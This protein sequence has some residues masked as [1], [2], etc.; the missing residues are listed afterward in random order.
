[1]SHFK[2]YDWMMGDGLKLKGCELLLYGLIYSYTINGKTLYEKEEA[3]AC[4]FSYSREHICRSI[5]VLL[6]KGYI[7]RLG[8]HPGAETYDYIVSQSVLDQLD[9]IDNISH[10]GVNFHH[11]PNE[12]KVSSL[13]DKISHNNKMEINEIDKGDTAPSLK[14][15]NPDVQEKWEVLLKSVKW[16]RRTYESLS[17]TAKKI[18]AYPPELAIRMISHTIEGDYPMVYDPSPDMI[19]KAKKEASSQI[20]QTQTNPNVIIE[21][22]IL[23]GKLY[24]I[25]PERYRLE[26]V[27]P[28]QR[29]RRALSCMSDSCRSIIHIYYPSTMKDWITREKTMIETTLSEVGLKTEFHYYE[30][31]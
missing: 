16:K 13:S 22:D 15:D 20:G 7:D 12:E 25:I 6:A 18:S 19:A 1:M 3:L 2:I 4:R 5:R 10:T 24:S 29:R 21:D 28:N 30:D 26:A 14:F 8:R 9:T 11:I 17:E 27:G 23:F 31:K